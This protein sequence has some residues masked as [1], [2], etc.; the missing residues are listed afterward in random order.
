MIYPKIQNAIEEMGGEAHLVRRRWHHEGRQAVYG[1]SVAY[2]QVKS[3][4]GEGK[5]QHTFKSIK[6]LQSKV[7][8]ISL[9]LGL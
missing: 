1:Q 9:S 2:N 7:Q 8:K 5:H 3:E 4:C 6:L